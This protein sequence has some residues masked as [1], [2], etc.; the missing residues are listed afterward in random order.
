[1]E[2]KF[3]NGSII[4][5]IEIKEKNI[6]SKPRTFFDVAINASARKIDAIIKEEDSRID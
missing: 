1:M 2:I 4:K 3:K 6:R 5:T